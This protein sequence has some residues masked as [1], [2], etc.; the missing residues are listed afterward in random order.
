MCG[1][2]LGFLCCLYVGIKRMCWEF[3]TFIFFLFGIGLSKIFLY[4]GK[5]Q[6][7][8][9][10]CK[11]AE[12]LLNSWICGSKLKL[13]W[14]ASFSVYYVQSLY[15]LLVPVFVVSCLQL[16]KKCQHPTALKSLSVHYLDYLILS[17]KAMWR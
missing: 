3:I 8:Y 16:H 11:N 6:F 17:S 10:A 13:Q 1:I 15:D 7:I 4:W 12:L 2:V 5:N 14:S 9:V